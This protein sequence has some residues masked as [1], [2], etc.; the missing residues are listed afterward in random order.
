VGAGELSAPGGELEIS[1]ALSPDEKILSIIISADRVRC[2]LLL[3]PLNGG[4]ARPVHELQQNTRGVVTHVWAPDGSAIFYTAKKDKDSWPWG[5]HRVSVDG[6]SPT[7]MVLEYKNPTFGV[8]LHPNGRMLAFAGR[9]GVSTM[10]E[11]WVME[12]FREELK[13]LGSEKGQ[14]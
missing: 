4:P 10:A 3:L 1:I 8:A 2:D 14:R 6:Q 5:I 13:K 7:E 9:N 12:N 11:V